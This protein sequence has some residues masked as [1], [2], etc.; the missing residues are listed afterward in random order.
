MKIGIIISLVQDYES[1]WINGIKL[2]AL[3]LSKMLNQIEGA[4]VYILDAGSK[5]SDLTKVSWDY[6]K[7]KV[8]KF[9]DME[10]ELDVMFMLGASLP[11][12]RVL[13]LRETNPTLKIVKYQCGNSY[14][15]DMER[16]IFNRA[17]EGEKPSWDRS[18]DETWLIPQQEYQNIEYY[19]TIYR[20]DSSKVKVV[21]FI[22]DPEPLDEFDKLLK[23]SGKLTPN[24]TPKT[25]EDKKLSVMEPNM[26]VVKYSLIPLMMAEEIFREY[27]EE[28]FKQIYIGSGKKLLKNKYYM[29]MIKHFDV[30]HTNKLKYVGR[31]PV[32]T[33]LSSETDIVISH[34]W[35][36]PL[37]YA[38]LDALYYGYPLVHNA[39]MIKDAGYYYS[40]FNISD[41]VD[42]LKFALNEHDNNLD[43][44]NKKNKSALSRY[45]S[46]NKKL[47]D[48]YRK[49]LDNLFE[50]GT[51]ELSYKY[52]W[53]TNLYK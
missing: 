14:V 37:N 33:F 52:N 27:G 8:A 3:N 1:M 40:D 39:E 42:Q 31:Y 36:N 19:K 23:I 47:V 13:K 32:S 46:T 18:H 48:T 11:E 17:G 16:V 51:H 28:A 22:W 34:Q 26:N 2:N 21:P 9:V 24:Y 4:D 12:S 29:S 44:Y 50:P 25:R 5:V 20:Q 7:Y 53:K 49:L 41:G 45:L 43:E 15:V 10:N 6:K 38:Y 35:E 30:M